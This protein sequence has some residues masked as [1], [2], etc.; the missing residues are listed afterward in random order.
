MFWFKVKKCY[1][2][3]TITFCSRQI[4]K[5]KTEKLAKKKL[6]AIYAKWPSQEDGSCYYLSPTLYGPYSSKKKAKDSTVTESS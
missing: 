4:V 5:A 6:D 2:A 1:S 3:G